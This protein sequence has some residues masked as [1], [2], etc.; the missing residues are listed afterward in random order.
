VSRAGHIVPG[1]VHDEEV[2]KTRP[3]G[4]ILC[5][6]G[7]LTPKRLEIRSIGRYSSRCPSVTVRRKRLRSFPRNTPVEQSSVKGF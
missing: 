3:V 2:P 5:E 1:H 6:Q 4:K 7:R